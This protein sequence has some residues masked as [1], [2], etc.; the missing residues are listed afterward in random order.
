MS[1]EV[2]GPINLRVSD[3]IDKAF[4]AIYSAEGGGSHSYGNR[5]ARSLTR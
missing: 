2:F 3:R 4:D 5:I 1:G